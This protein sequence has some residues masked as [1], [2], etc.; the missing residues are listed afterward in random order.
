MQ[1]HQNQ[2]RDE[3]RVRQESASRGRFAAKHQLV[4][5]P[6]AD[7]GEFFMDI[8]LHHERKEWTYTSSRFFWDTKNVFKAC[9]WILVAAIVVA[10]VVALLE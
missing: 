10:I 5:S 7:D 8:D 4:A 2:W 3:R 6:L 1:V 9:L